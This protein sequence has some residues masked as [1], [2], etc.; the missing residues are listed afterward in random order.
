M[1]GIAGV[2]GDLAATAPEATLRAMS[3]ALAHRGP[4]DEGTWVRSAP[5]VGLAHRRLAVLDLSDAG[6]QPMASPSGR[7]VVSWNGEL[8]NHSE[9]RQEL[10]AGGSRFRSRTDTEVFL[11]AVDRWGLHAALPKTRG[12]F[13]F[14]LWDHDTAVLYLAR[15]RFGEKPLYYREAPGGGAFASELG[16]LRA[17]P[18]FQPDVDRDALTLLL[19]HGYIPAPHT[20]YRNVAKVLP[21]EVVELRP[22]GQVARW[23]YWS[24]LDEATRAYAARRPIDLES[25]ADELD[26]L[27]RAAVAEQAVADVPVGVFLSGGVDSSS[28][29]AALAGTRDVRTFTMGFEDPRYDEAPYAAAV[30]DHFGTRHESV[31]VGE[32]DVL[33]LLDQLPGMFG[34]PFADA[35][36]LPTALVAALA[37]RA[38]TV[39]LSGDGGDEMF[40]GYGRYPAAIRLWGALGAVP[41]PVRRAGRWAGA[42]TRRVLGAM[43]AKTSAGPGE[44]RRRLVVGAGL[45]PAADASELYLR[46]VSQ[47]DDPAAVV[48]GGVEPSTP[49]SMGLPPAPSLLDALTAVD[50]ITYLPDD[51][52]VKVDRTA[53]AVG[54][55]VRAP[56][57]DH[58]IFRFA[59]SLPPALRMEGGVQKRV[60]RHWLRRHL[61]GDLVDRPKRGFAVPLA[62]WLRGPLRAWAEDLLAAD[63]LRAQGYFD[64]AEVRKRWSEHISGRHDWSPHLWSVLQFQAWHGA[65]GAGG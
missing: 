41:A 5:A 62:R 52:L 24:T 53:M 23:A 54:L 47:W 28:V 26:T 13:A 21:G 18:G 55:E 61:P 7:Y 2:V 4:D 45:V 44:L 37:G 33:A 11:C 36:Q 8:Y 1:C 60:L 39:C 12:M 25:A 31:R 17:I 59:M 3:A 57:L 42:A 50:L 64:T 51:I 43:P 48:L 15:D 10:E 14:A 16:A 19:R 63:A 20:I 56:F 40:A 46:L 22:G 9:L 32:A 6:H 38:V 65:G 27:L 29:V 30:A 49:V 34:E 35:S 58:R